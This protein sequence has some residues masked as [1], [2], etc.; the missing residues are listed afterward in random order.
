VNRI[1]LLHGL[2]MRSLVMRPLAARLRAEGFAV[3]TVDYASIVRGPTPCIEWL[4]QRLRNPG[5]ADTHLVG[6]SLG[7]VIAVHA[8]LAAGEGFRGRVV[9]LGSPLA[10]SATARRVSERRGF[11]ALIG[12]SAAVLARGIDALPVGLQVGSVAGR[13]A[14]GFGQLFHRF[15]Q[16][17]DGSVAV[18]ETCLPGLTDH[19]EVPVSHTGLVYSREVARLTAGFLRDGRFPAIDRA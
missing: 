3:E 17:N 8:A 13:R 11:S 2:W 9:C 19:V 10:G 4:T 5:E 6:H 12:R 1:L 18:A 7:G 14:L 16:P 15:E